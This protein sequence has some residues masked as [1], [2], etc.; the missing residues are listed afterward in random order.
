MPSMRSIVAD[1]VGEPSSPGSGDSWPER[2]AA[3]H[4]EASTSEEIHG[5]HQILTGTG[6]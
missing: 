3:P 1:T 4:R 5:E 2:T 6:G